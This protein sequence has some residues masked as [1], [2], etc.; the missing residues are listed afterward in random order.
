M[1]KKAITALAKSADHDVL[2]YS[3]YLVPVGVLGMIVFVVLGLS[4]TPGPVFW[5]S[6]LGIVMVTGIG[7]WWFNQGV[8]ALLE[9]L[10]L[11]DANMLPFPTDAIIASGFEIGLIGIIIV[12]GSGVLGLITSFF[13]ERD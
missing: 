6:G 4:Q 8:D 3:M 10:T 13:V 11:L 9:L 2:S 7:F 5:I 12:G 1:R